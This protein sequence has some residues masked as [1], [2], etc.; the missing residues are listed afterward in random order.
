MDTP[1]PQSPIVDEITPFLRLPPELLLLIFKY[2]VTSTK[3]SLSLG[4]I[5]LVCRSFHECLRNDPS[6]WTTILITLT[7]LESHRDNATF[8]NFTRM[9]TLALDYSRGR[10]L[11]LTVSLLHGSENH[12]NS[13]NQL[14]TRLKDRPIRDFITRL[15]RVLPRCRELTIESSLWRDKETL[16]S[17]VKRSIED[18]NAL[19]RLESLTMT[20]D[21]THTVEAFFHPNVLPTSPLIRSDDPDDNETTPFPS[22]ENLTIDN[23]AH[24]WRLLTLSGLHTLRLINIP[25]YNSPSYADL[26][27]ILLSNAETLSTLE[28][29]NITITNTKAIG[30]SLTLPNVRRM[31]IGFG[32]PKDL[33]WAAQMLDLPALEELV[34]EDRVAGLK[35]ENQRPWVSEAKKRQT[36]EGFR[37]LVRCFRLDCIQRL[38]LKRVVFHESHSQGLLVDEAPEDVSFAF[39]FFSGFREVKDLEVW[40]DASS[41]ALSNVAQ[42]FS[43]T[44]FPKLRSCLFVEL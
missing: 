4:P 19:S 26:H 9:I 17:L 2:L 36:M 24:T 11:S 41:L 31:T 6:S 38:I 10:P 40:H 13:D 25:S 34:I 3:N 35:L 32:H 12:L 5:A 29:S 37:G 16:I 20:Y 44:L 8:L 28:L 33:V 42:S 14:G 27:R 18:N 15:F 39:R 7:T 22:L 21:P 30:E 43:D 23:V 1:P